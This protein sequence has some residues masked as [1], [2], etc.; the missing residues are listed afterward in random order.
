MSTWYKFHTLWSHAFGK[1]GGGR[2][3][4]VWHETHHYLKKRPNIKNQT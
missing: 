3:L 2:A 1:D 4:Q